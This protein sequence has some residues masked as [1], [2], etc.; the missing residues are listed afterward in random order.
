MWEVPIVPLELPSNM[1]TANE[2]SYSLVRFDEDPLNSVNDVPDQKRRRVNGSIATNFRQSKRHDDQFTKAGAAIEVSLVAPTVATLDASA[3]D[4]SE[5]N[6]RY[7]WVKDY[8]MEVADSKI[9][10]CFMLLVDQGAISAAMAKDKETTTS[11]RDSSIRSTE[12]AR[13]FP[14][15]SRVDMRKMT[16][17]ESMPHECTVTRRREEEEQ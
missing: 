17:E 14:V 13:Y 11:E 2:K 3:E 8:R 4:E 15:R 5:E 12:V 10:D 7:E 9:D 16:V 1:T 6:R